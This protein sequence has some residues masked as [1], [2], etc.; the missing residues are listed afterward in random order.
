MK[1]RWLC[2][3]LSFSILGS[4][5]RV[6]SEEEE[7]REICFVG[8]IQEL[9]QVD[10]NG[11]RAGFDNG[12]KVQLYIVEQDEEGLKLPASEDFYQ[13]T[14]DAEGNINFED[15]EKHVY[16]DNPINIYGF[17]C[18]GKGGNPDNLSA[19]PVAV[20]GEQVTGEALLSSDFLYVKSEKRYR[21]SSDAI[22]LSF[23]HQFAKLR[24][25]FRT[26]TPEVVDL[27]EITQLEVS[28]VV[29]EGDFNITTGELTLGNALD[30]IQVKPGR[31]SEVIV[32]PQELQGGEVL[33]RFTQGGK[34]K[35]YSVPAEGMS[36]KKGKLYRCDIL[37]NQYPG[38]GNK[39]I[40]I[41]TQIEDWDEAEPPIHIV[42]EEG[43]R[44][45]VAL[46]DVSNGVNINRVDLY[47][48]SE[49]K[50]RDMLD[51]PVIN[52]KMEFM[53]PRE[54][55]GGTLLLSKAHFYT[56][57]GEE[58]DYYFKG[59]ELLGDNLD[60]LSLAAPKVGDTWGNGKIFVVGKMTGY[61]EKTSYFVTNVT[62]INAYRGRIVAGTLL[63]N[64][65]WADAKAKGKSFA[66]G[67]DSKYDGLVN[68]EAIE[69]FAA[70]NGET[71][72]MYP[73][74]K[75]CKDL[76]E[77]WYFP[78]LN[79][80]RWIVIHK[81][82]LGIDMAISTYG[83]STEIDEKNCGGVASNPE[84]DYPFN[85]GSMAVWPVRAY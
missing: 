15:G 45:E 47:L 9:Q 75:A 11:S 14:S 31:E 60:E 16:P 81:E 25:N 33:F 30:D 51:V 42:F 39:D 72:D 84:Q 40:V 82:Y 71:L 36:L 54:T 83:S 70:T 57:A 66:V 76:G 5:S 12:D 53:F 68:L 37:I 32:L 28:N 23:G 80:I 41:N 56:E 62:G 35:S 24:F 29:R 85:K 73:A 44:V 52:N 21:T 10:L 13:M 78:A 7:E 79:E 48:A 67:A 6:I 58:F 38:V 46:T 2:Y 63:G 27:D 65:Y 43:Q 26:D 3:F 1:R 19:L 34:E 69:T 22:A 64:R 4:C 61:D 50:T 8:N 77:G 20:A 74:F 17:Y 59:K 18:K 49:T 55:K